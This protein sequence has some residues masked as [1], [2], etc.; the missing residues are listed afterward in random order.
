MD[1]TL[2][3]QAQFYLLSLLTQIH[4]AAPQSLGEHL[5]HAHP[6]Q[7]KQQLGPPFPPTVDLPKGL[8]EHRP[9]P[10]WPT[11]CI[12][13]SFKRAGLTR[14]GEYVWKNVA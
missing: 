4:W 13:A 6:L 9:V 7:G 11:V 12:E 3:S 10:A 8:G 2:C 5:A 14:F 1:R